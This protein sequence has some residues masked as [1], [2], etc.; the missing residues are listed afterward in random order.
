M[1]ILPKELSLIVYRYIHHEVYRIVLQELLSV[2][3]D[4]LVIDNIKGYAISDSITRCANFK[5][6]GCKNW[7]TCTHHDYFF[8][9]CSGCVWG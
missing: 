5:I 9:L 8:P 7:I 4:L 6:V 1:D 3:D 2:T